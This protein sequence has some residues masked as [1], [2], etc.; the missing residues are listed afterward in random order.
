ML[1]HAGIIVLT[2]TAVFAF[3]HLLSL[4]TDA[5]G[6]RFRINPGVRGAT[7]DAV[8]SSFPELCAVFVA[9]NAGA[10]DAGVGTSS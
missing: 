7:L 2:T 9:L 10:F 8:A 3:S 4:G 6:R 1:L 5:L